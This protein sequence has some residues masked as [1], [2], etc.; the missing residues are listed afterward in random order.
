MRCGFCNLFTLANPSQPLERGYLCTLKLEA[1]VVAAALGDAQFTRM[2]IGG[3][4]PTF[5]AVNELHELFDLVETNFSI[6]PAKIPVS[7]E[8]SPQTATKEKLLVLKAR[9]V[10]RVSIGVQSFVEAEVQAVGRSQSSEI[11]CKALN[12]IKT[13]GFATLNVDLIYGLPGQTEETWRGSLASALQFQPEEVYIY[14]LYVRSLTGLARSVSSWDDARLRLYRIGRDVLLQAGYEQVSMRMFQLPRSAKAG[15]PDYCC[16]T[17]GMVGVGCG[18]RSYT[19][20][21]HYSGPYAVDRGRI[22]SLLS[23]YIKSTAASF[24]EIGYGYL[25]DVDDQARRFVIQ[26]VLQSAGMALGEY[27]TRFGDSCFAQLPEICLMMEEGL[28]AITAE[29][30]HLTETGFEMSDNIGVRLYSSAV[31]QRMK[32]Y[33]LA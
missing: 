7:V 13:I 15:A 23:D 14:P 30:L 29:R 22:K 8:T 27:Q 4:T 31:V 9:G 32:D 1:Q 6:H 3:G 26:S 5:L 24:A 33:E 17:D 12:E 16:Q 19:K 11:V 20:S 2:A 21:L 18:A 28:L 10:D 25:L